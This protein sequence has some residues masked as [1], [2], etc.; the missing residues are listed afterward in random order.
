MPRIS[1]CPAVAAAALAAALACSAAGAAEKL[2]LGFLGTLSGP[3]AV[4]GTQVRD[5]FKLAVEELGGRIG[6]LPTEVLVVDDQQKP[7]VGRQAANKLIESDRI[8]VLVGPLISSVVNAVVPVVNQAKLPMIGA[9]GAPSSLAGAECSPYFFS[10]SWQG[11][12]LAEAMGIALQEKRVQRLYLMVPNFP[13]G[14]EVV[15]GVK[16]YYK[17]EIVGEV[18]TPLSQLDFAAELA[19]LR[20][21][22]PDAAFV[23]YPGGLGIQ[24][25]KQYAQAGLKDKI[26]LYTAYT[27]DAATLPAIGE[28]ALGV[29]TAEFWS[30]AIDNPANKKFV[31][32]FRRKY[33]YPA[34]SYAAQGYDAARILDAAVRKVQGKVEDRAA[35]LAAIKVAEFSSVR[36]PFKYS[37]NHFPIQDLYLGKIVKGDDGK[38]MMQLGRKML[39]AHA[40]P[41]ASKCPLK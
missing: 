12:T 7:D 25:M 1:L 2:K 21:V 15:A 29:Q 38:P 32:S 30:E 34:S 3:N 17:G 6:G 31:E 27:I 40:D 33:N 35:L 18:Y 10:S 11:D 20:S 19:Q 24:F 5:G 22:N 14:K 26:P 41:Y 36:G 13:G 37:N 8:D 9:G 4:M 23:F 39:V 16:R 28:A